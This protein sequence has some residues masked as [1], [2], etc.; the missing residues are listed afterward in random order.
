MNSIARN[1][2][3]VEYASG[4]RT[5]DKIYLDTSFTTGAEFQTKSQGLA[6]LLC[7]VSA[8]PDDTIFH[9]QAWTFGCFPCPSRSQQLRH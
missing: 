8:Y 6:E 2:C 3:L 5:L 7:K 9:L 1:P 4:I